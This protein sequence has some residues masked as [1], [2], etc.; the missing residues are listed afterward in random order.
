MKIELVLNTVT[1]KP[2]YIQ[3]NYPS[4]MSAIKSHLT[5]NKFP[6][7]RIYRK[8]KKKKVSEIIDEIAKDIETY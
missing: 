3:E 5:K 4:L 8:K 2:E 7:R 6:K 1:I